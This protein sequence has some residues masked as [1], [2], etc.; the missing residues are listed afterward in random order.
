MN[1]FS[2]KFHTQKTSILFHSKFLDF[3]RIP[4]FEELTNRTTVSAQPFGHDAS[5]QQCI[6]PKT[7][8]QLHRLH[9]TPFQQPFHRQRKFSRPCQLTIHNDSTAKTDKELV[10]NLKISFPE[11]T[12][13][14]RSLLPVCQFSICCILSQLHHV[15]E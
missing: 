6:A 12:I 4:L 1:V 15:R 5:G 11:A 2:N 10:L 3:Q 14:R 8:H 7:I 9:P 13:F